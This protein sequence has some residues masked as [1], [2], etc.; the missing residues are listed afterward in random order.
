[1]KMSIQ[2]IRG[3]AIMLALWA[4]FLLSALVISWALDIDSRLSF[5]SEGTRMLKAEAAA[6]SGAEVA[7]HPM[8]NPGS[9]NLSGQVGNGA[10]YKARLTGEGG[11]LDLNWHTSAATGPAGVDVLRKYLENK[12]IDLNERD[13]MIDSL[14]DW[15]EQNVGV[16]RLNAPPE[17]ADYHPAHAPLTPIDELKKVA[18]WAEFTSQPG[19]ADDLT[20]DSR[21]G[22]DLAWASRDVLLALPGMTAQIVDRFLELR[23]GPDGIDGTEDDM[24]QTEEQARAALGLKDD[25]QFLVLKQLGVSF[26]GVQ[27]FRVVSVGTAGKATRTV[28]MVFNRVGVGVS[29][30]SWKEF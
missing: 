30:I 3:A 2:K 24:I 13:T 7:L 27:M 19:W 9:S 18:G 5:S 28:Q 26:K 22:V 15:V 11:R 17:S 20:V 21:K 25:R 23:R 12:G 8:I 29:V 14:I 6:C 16:H 10:T 4:L 1:M